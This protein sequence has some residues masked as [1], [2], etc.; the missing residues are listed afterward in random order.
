[1]DLV[2]VLYVAIAPS[3]SVRQGNA[4]GDANL[5]VLTILAKVMVDR[6]ELNEICAV[7][8]QCEWL[9]PSTACF[10][11]ATGSSWMQEWG[12]D[13]I[14]FVFPFYFIV[15]E[16]R[17]AGLVA[18]CKSTLSLGSLRNNKHLEEK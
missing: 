15:P 4:E 10:L 7:R 14:L 3:F 12:G 11:Q 8:A 9:N 16:D 2:V 18:V 6:F 1:M 17:H 13:S 5:S